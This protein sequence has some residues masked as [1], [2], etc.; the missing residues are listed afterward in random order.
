V[1]LGFGMFVVWKKM[2]RWRQPV[3]SVAAAASV[4]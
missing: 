2:L 4:A 1:P 3:G